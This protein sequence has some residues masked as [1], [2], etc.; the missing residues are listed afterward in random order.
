MKRYDWDH[1]FFV[2]ECEDGDYVLYEDVKK[3][4][5]SLCVV[6][7]ELQRTVRVVLEYIEKLSRKT[8]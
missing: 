4:I 3:E 6:A 8:K 2:K 1:E 5:D 7:E